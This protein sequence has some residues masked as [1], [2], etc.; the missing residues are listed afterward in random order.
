MGIL[1]ART[2]EWVVTPSSRGSSQLRDWTQVYCIA[3]G[4]FTYRTTGKALIQYDSQIAHTLTSV[5]TA[6]TKI[7]TPKTSFRVK[8]EQFKAQYLED[9]RHGPKLCLQLPGDAY[10]N[11]WSANASLELRKRHFNSS[12]ALRGKV[13]PQVAVWRPALPSSTHTGSGGRVYI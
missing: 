5:W 6:D 8:K 3:G 7:L 4:F 11:S 1:Q 10:T 9:L 2:L 13:D 12:T